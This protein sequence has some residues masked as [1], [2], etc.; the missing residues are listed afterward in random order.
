MHLNDAL[1]AGE[2]TDEGFVAASAATTSLRVTAPRPEAEGAEGGAPDPVEAMA[3]AI[4]DHLSIDGQGPGYDSVR[5]LKSDIRSRGIA[6]SDNKW[7][8]AVAWL[9]SRNLLKRWGVVDQLRMCA[10]GGCFAS[11]ARWTVLDVAAHI[12]KCSGDGRMP[13]DWARNG[14]MHAHASYLR[15]KGSVRTS[16]CT[17]CD[18]PPPTEPKLGPE[19]AAAFERAL[20]AEPKLR[21]VSQLVDVLRLLVRPT[22]E[23][24]HGCIW[25]A[26]VKP[27]VRPWVG[28]GRGYPPKS[29][30]DPDPTGERWLR[31]TSAAELM[32][33]AD[34]R[35]PAETET[36]K[37]L[38]TSEAWNA[39]TKVLIDRL[40]EYTSHRPLKGT[41]QAL[42][43]VPEL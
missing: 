43:P 35:I 12:G 31:V 9:V 14:L 41:D 33:E 17:Y 5:Q 1:T 10:A 34:P 29:A 18:E 15:G 27:L 39:V 2:F 36:E 11:T 38:R 13:T 8:D 22:D 4:Y 42:L 19:A 21:A 30:Q 40:Y 3:L 26:I 6:V 24:C 25:E 32:R 7:P 37:W 23:M 16:F 28:W 20:Q